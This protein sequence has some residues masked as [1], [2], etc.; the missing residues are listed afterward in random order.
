MIAAAI[1]KKQMGKTLLI[2]VVAIIVVVGA[3]YFAGKGKDENGGLGS[4]IEGETEE[5]REAYLA[6]IGL[7][8]DP[9]SS[10]ADV[11]VPEEWDERF[12]TY[13][14]TLKT[15]GF[16]LEGLKGKTVKKCTYIVT[17][18]DDIGP[19]VSAVLLVYNGEIVGGHLIDNLSGKLYAL[20]DVDTTQDNLEETEDTILPVDKKTGEENDEGEKAD[21]SEQQT[22]SFPED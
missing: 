12:T 7:Q 10:I 22:I 5:Q 11:G 13:N 9:T 4:K 2:I 18:R 14:E 19:N 1:G 3:I 8:V 17:N 21:D 6:S 15:T 20:F 16:D